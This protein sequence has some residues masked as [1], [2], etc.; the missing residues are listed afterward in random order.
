MS[1]PT[2]ATAACSPR[3]YPSNGRS[4]RTDLFAGFDQQQQRLVVRRRHIEPAA[5]A[6]DCAV[7]GL[8]LGRPTALHVLEHGWLGWAHVA[9]VLADP[10]RWIG[11]RQGGGQGGGG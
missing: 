8:D 9:A 2:F 4:P 7:D 1:T 6:N 10:C 3:S 11:I 5:L